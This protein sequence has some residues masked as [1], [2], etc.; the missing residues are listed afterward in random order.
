MLGMAMAMAMAMA[1][2]LA[3]GIMFATATSGCSDDV[4]LTIGCDFEPTAGV[5]PDGVE[6]GAELTI[7]GSGPGSGVGAGFAPGNG[8]APGSGTPAPAVPACRPGIDVCKDGYTVTMPL[9]QRGPITLSDLVNFRPA[10]GVHRMEPDGWSVVGLDTN[11]FADTDAHVQGDLLLGIPAQV[12]FTPVAFRWDYGDGSSATRAS[13]GG[14]WQALGLGE[15]D[16]TATSHAYLTRGRYAISLTIDFRAEYRFGA[17]P[18]GAWV[19]IAG[20]VPIASD[21][22]SVEVLRATTV[23]VERGCTALRPGPGC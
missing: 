21:P 22:L 5:T 14:S 18:M 8:V 9:D 16:A 10:P 23:L 11:F 17:G 2:V 15:F 19:P 13:K 4:I 3:G 7:P 6:L 12:R 20:T 1:L